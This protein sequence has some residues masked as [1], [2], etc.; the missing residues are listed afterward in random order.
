METSPVNRA[1]FEVNAMEPNDK[2]CGNIPQQ[3][4]AAGSPKRSVEPGRRVTEQYEL[5]DQIGPETA[6]SLIDAAVLLYASDTRAEVW[7]LRMEKTR[8]TYRICMLNLQ[9]DFEALCLDWE[10]GPASSAA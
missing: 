8:R 6:R 5:V 4:G 1:D 9:H 3:D 10:D 7:R 2:N